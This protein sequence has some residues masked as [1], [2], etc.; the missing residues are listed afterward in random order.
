MREYRTAQVAAALGVH[1]NTVRLYE[2]WGLISRPERSGNGYRVFTDLHVWQ[3]R[4]A[5]TAF[6][7]EIL[8]NGLRRQMVQMVKTAAKGDMDTALAL[9]GEYISRLRRERANAEEAIGIVR[10]LL[11]G[12]G[13]EACSSLKR[14][15]ASEYLGVSM[16]TLRN[17]E[18]N[19]LLTVK[20][21]ENGYRVYTDG[22]LKRLKVIRSLRCA[23]Y[24]LEAILR[25]LCQLDRDPGADIRA[26]LNTPNPSEDIISACDQLIGSLAAAEEN[27]L[28]LTEMLMDMKGLFF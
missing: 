11:S 19:G 24:S 7:V 9:T 23:N 4:L 28:V 20:R 16:D 10:Q 25:M 1:P 12:G 14:K 8:Q 26:A 6:Q 21:R 27:A 5:R 18:M 13:G 2:E 17:W 22:D 15:E 3:L